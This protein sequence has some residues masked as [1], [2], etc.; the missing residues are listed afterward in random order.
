M[1]ILCVN[2]FSVFFFTPSFLT[3][4]LVNT[5]NVQSSCYSLMNYFPGNSNHSTKHS[6]RTYLTNAS[7]YLESN[8]RELT[9][10]CSDM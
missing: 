6:I 1:L 4:G 5:F 7:Q 10:A 2:F 9:R 3:Q 8:V